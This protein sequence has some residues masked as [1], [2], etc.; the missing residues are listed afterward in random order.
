M[1]TLPGVA[2]ALV[3]LSSA[4]LLAAAPAWADEGKAP[5][6]AKA[7]ASGNV[8]AAKAAASGDGGAAKKD[9]AKAKHE[10]REAEKQ[11]LAAKNVHIPKDKLKMESVRHAR[12]VA[13]L[14]RIRAVAD[15][16]K[17]PAAVQRADSL[18]AKE[19][20][21]HEK[22]VMK[23]AQGSGSAASASAV[24]PVAP[25]ASAAG[26]TVAPKKAGAK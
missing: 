19:N 23:F 17:D 24:K 7:A 22:W 18:A 9:I 12:R 1:R 4:L 10:A 3:W 8:G 13:H 21:R 6:E 25:V 14:R 16:A 11:W 20:D 2:R 5:K 26:G 15:A